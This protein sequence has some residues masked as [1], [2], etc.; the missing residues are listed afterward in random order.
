MQLSILPAFFLLLL[1]TLFLPEKVNAFSG[2]SISNYSSENGL[3]QNSIRGIELDKDGF[4]WLATEAGLVRFDGQRLKVYDRDHYPVMHSNRISAIW[5][6]PAGRICFRDEFEHILGNYTFNEH[7][8]IVQY[9]HQPY[10]GKI[11]QFKDSRFWIRQ[12]TVFYKVKGTILWKMHI[13]GLQHQELHYWGHMN[14][15]CY[16]RNGKG[17]VWSIDSVRNRIQV[18]IKGLPPYRP[19]GDNHTG[20]AYDLYEQNDTL[21]I[22]ADK[23]IY[24]ICEPRKGYFEALLVLKTDIPDIHIYRYYPQLNLHLI[25]TFTHGLYLIRNKQFTTLK[26]QNGFG[27]YYP[28]APFG[29]SGVLTDRGI[30]FPASSRFDYPFKN[31]IA[32]RS[33]LRDHLGNYWLNRAHLNKCKI[34][35]LD[36]KLKVVKNFM[37]AY[38]AN[39]FREAPDGRVWLCSFE[40]LR[41]GYAQADSIHWLPSLW[42][43]KKVHTFLPADNENFWIGGTRV[44][45]KLNVRT[46]RQ[47]HYSSLEKYT[48]ETLYLDGHE[49][50]WVGT[51]GNGFFAIKNERIIKLP[52]D[53]NGSLKD[54]HSFMEDKNGFLWMSSN[55]GLFRCKKSDLDNYLSAATTNIYYQCFKRESGFNTN[56]FNG[57]CTPSA[58]VLGNGKFSFPSLDGLVQFDPDSIHE[59]LPVNKIVVDQILVDGKPQHRASGASIDIDPSFRYLE[60]QV[61][62]P[63]F[64]NPANQYLEY[65]LNG[66][67]SVWQPLKEGNAVVF[68]NLKHGHYEL[69]FRK[70]SGF[71]FENVVTTGIRLYVKPFFYQTW[72]FRMA[73]LA[74]IALLVYLIVRL[75]YLYLIKRNKE[76]EQEVSQRTLKLLQANKLKEKM[77]MMVGHDLQSPLHFMSILSRHV[78]QSLDR[79]QISEA[80]TGSEEISTTATKIHAFVE[81][82]GLWSRLQDESFN[83]STRKFRLSDMIG[84]LALFYKEILSQNNNQLEY[85]TAE[86]YEVETNRELLKAMLRNLLDNANKH[87]RN[88][89]IRIRCYRDNNILCLMIADTGK[90]MSEIELNNIRRRIDNRTETFVTSHT[91]KLGYQLIIDFAVSLDV[92]LHIDSY[93]GI[94]TT[95][96]ISGLKARVT[97]QAD[98]AL[99]PGETIG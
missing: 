5:L 33:L 29:D 31:F 95:V 50:L 10:G 43:N 28:Q 1:T 71:G 75:R 46:G 92:R 16:Y 23:A 55:N 78:Q 19:S 7:G 35:K 76:L 81:E 26:H 37:S 2:F 41:L 25:G 73:A 66:L 32:Y 40:G 96:V 17:E 15:K 12:D 77:L 79:Q 39:C 60:V 14:R 47:I 68:N 49:V 74:F 18:H 97:A 69:K 56:E 94:G 67:D 85:T 59:I 70:R 13:P 53:K 99:F 54:V 83:I 36:N 6:D 45:A 80:R 27:N 11:G 86:E 65:R 48:I 88:G 30:V 52:L 72:Y 64:G 93:K 84:E 82:F 90:G 4:I 24:R 91:S 44:M 87:T 42:G 89:H 22:A 58:I 3:P 62:S 57:S 21:Y 34:V 61:A 8:R 98:Q 9:P 20:F 51:T 63:Y 38:T